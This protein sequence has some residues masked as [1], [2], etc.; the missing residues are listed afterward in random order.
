MVTSSHRARE[1]DANTTLIHERQASCRKRIKINPYISIIVNLKIMV[2][3]AHLIIK[4]TL[5]V[6]FI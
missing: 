4:M 6:W 5:R 1:L 3:G 2:L